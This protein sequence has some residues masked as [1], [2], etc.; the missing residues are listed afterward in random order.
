MSDF[1]KAFR[2]S[3]LDASGENVLNVANPRLGEMLDALNLGYFI[4]ENTVQE[5]DPER[6]TYKE[7]FIVEFNQRLYKNIT[8]IT[9]AEPFNPLKWKKMR[10]DPEWE[11]VDSSIGSNVGDFLFLTAS[12]PIT[13]TLPE[14]PRTGDTVTIKDGKGVL[15]TYPTTVAA[16]SGL[17][18]QSYGITGSIES[19]TTMT[20]NRPSSTVYFVYNGLAW[21][22]QT[23]QDSYNTFIDAGHASQQGN[24]LVDGGY[25]ANVDE[26][27][28]YS[29]AAK[30]IAVSLPLNPVAGDMV[31]LQDLAFQNDQTR[32]QIGT[33]PNISDQ[34]IL[35]PCTYQY[36]EELTLDNAG[37]IEILYVGGDEKTWVM[38]VTN[39]T[40]PWNHIG[41]SGSAQLIVNRR[42]DIDINDAI[43]SMTITLPASPVEGDWVELSNVK[44]PGKE[45][46]VQIHPSFGDDDVGHGA[47]EYKI[48]RSLDE[49][50]MVKYSDFAATVDT[51]NDSFTVNDEDRGYSFI[52]FYDATRKVWDFADISSRIDIADEDHRKRPGLVPLASPTEALAHGVEY[53]HS[54]DA[55]DAWANQNPL[56]DHAITVETLDARRAAEDQVGMARVAKLTSDEALELSRTILS[57]NEGT[58]YPESV[59]RHDIF[60][61]P[62]SLNARTAT[63]TRRGVVEIATQNETRST[64]NDVQVLSPRKFHAAQ[65]EENLTGVGKLV[66]ASDN[67]NN[68]GTLDS[69]TNMRSDRTLDGSNGSVY[70]KSNHTRFVTPKMLDEYRATENQP[71]TLWVAKTTELRINDSDVDDAIITPK[72]LAAWT[73]SETIRGIVRTATLAE[74]RATSGSG[75]AWDRTFITPSTLNDRTATETRRG[76]AEIATQSEFDAGTDNTRIVAPLKLKTWL[77]RDHFVTAGTDGL[78]HTGTIWDDVTLSIAPATET[79]RGTLQV[80]TQTETNSQSSPLDNVML[81]PKKLNARRAT[82]S[83]AGIVRLATA[84]EVDAGTV[85]N[86]IVLTPSDLLRWTRTSSNSR[87]SETRYG[88]AR[89]ATALETFVGD[90]TSGSSQDYT[91]YDRH[92]YSVSPYALHYALRNYLPLNA[93]A[94]D[95]ELLD[96][97][98]STQFARSDA[99]DFITGTYTFTDNEIKIQGANPRIE[100]KDTTDGNS[101]RELYFQSG[102]IG[103]TDG[104]D[105]WQLKVSENGYTNVYGGLEVSGAG[106]FGSS[107]QENESSANGRS[108][109]TGTLRTKYLGIDN[110]AATAA[111]WETART[112]TFS[113]DLTGSV[114]FD[115][116]SNVTASVQVNNNSHAHT[117]ENITS[118]T[119]NND[120]LR[121]AS[122]SN[123]GIVQVTD[124]VR[125]ADPSSTSATHT[126]LSAGAGKELS[127]RIDLHTPDGGTGNDIKYRDYIQVGSVRMSTTNQGVLE[128]TFGHAI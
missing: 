128:F 31:H 91:A 125:T 15:S 16:A 21:T 36:V 119:V 17:T 108:P 109:G 14:S 75:E 86:E 6:S 57:G 110:M 105:N 71:G 92:Q 67:I 61:T 112:V 73:A 22:Y 95:S 53:A 32:I 23:D 96:G 38:T 101:T 80:A 107:I 25:I 117:G 1:R 46:T 124:D 116:S 123:A 68:D 51:F 88:T 82:E 100:F 89:S 114:S 122:R 113:G 8:P 70:D 7:D 87:S 121:K 11:E 20:M 77:D 60:I 3:G 41:D 52:L 45:V 84:S 26:T 44:T 42:Y 72:K 64:S 40:S 94:D 34:R 55:G 24:Y 103:F 10:N 126:A 81:T 13:I 47:N 5:Y 99:D 85:S 39:D 102:D 12:S 118:G 28:T 59:F 27:I 63:E 65:A 120:R 66:L 33:H 76:V 18:I 48:V 79:Q 74:A 35:D 56:K 104:T 97:L 106:S 90:S 115:G 43:S 50:R 93:K 127:E 111:K 9:T 4:D 98:N 58:R 83:L 2:A 19:E 54:E 69:T 37:L 30:K 78:S 29:A 49:Y 62:R